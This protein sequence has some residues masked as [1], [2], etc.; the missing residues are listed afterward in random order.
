MEKSIRF[1]VFCFLVLCSSCTDNKDLPSLGS[2][3]FTS[4]DDCDIRLFDSRGRQ[5][6]HEPYETGKPPVVVDMK[7]TGIFVIHAEGA[8]VLKKEPVTYP[9]GNIDYYI[10]FR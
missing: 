3:T 10:D 8:G 9:G 4:S 7:S 2:I 5:V 6:A 1:L